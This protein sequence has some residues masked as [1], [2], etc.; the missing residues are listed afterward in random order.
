MKQLP[1]EKGIHPVLTTQQHFSPQEALTI[2]VAIQLEDERLRGRLLL[3]P[4]LRHS[5][6][7]RLTKKQPLAPYSQTMTQSLWLPLHIEA[8]K[9]QLFPSEWSALQLGD[10]LVL[11][12]CSV[13]PKRLEGKVLLTLDGKPA[14]RAKLKDHQLK[15]LEFPLLHKDSPPMAKQNENQEE[16]F[17]DFN[18]SPEESFEDLEEELLQEE[19]KEEEEEEEPSPLPPQEEDKP[20]GAQI[21]LVHLD[22]VPLTIVVELGQIQMSADQILKLEPGNLLPLQLSPEQGVVLT[23]NGRAVAKGEL[24]R[25]GE[26]LGVR[27][28]QLGHSSSHV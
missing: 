7:D 26:V 10:C 14:F 11:D 19:E 27:I 3:S 12:S 4:D 20:P 5:W 8:G 28:T 1:I 22:D 21:G 13:D 23:V 17:E 2:E 25:I 15:I 16:E 18:S 6:V 24:I 9:V